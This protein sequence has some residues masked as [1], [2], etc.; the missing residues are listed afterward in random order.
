MTYFVKLTGTGTFPSWSAT[1]D[2]TVSGEV[3]FYQTNDL[4]FGV[5]ASTNGYIG[6]VG[7]FFGVKIGTAFYNT[8]IPVTLSAK[9]AFSI[10]RPIGDSTVSITYGGTT[11]TTSNA[12]TLIIDAIGK[13]DSGGNFASTELDIYLLTLTNGTDN[14]EYDPRVSGGTGTTLTDTVQAKNATLTGTVVWEELPDSSPISFSTLIPFANFHYQKDGNGQGNIVR[15]V[16]FSGAPTSLRYRI[17]DATDDTTVIVDW[18]VFDASPSGGVSVLDILVDASVTPMHMQV[19]NED[20][21]VVSA[22]D[23][24]DFYVG[25]VILIMGQSLAEDMSTDGAV[26]A[27]AGYFKW[28][29]T[30]GVTTA[31]GTG[32]Y[33][34]ARGSI[35]GEGCS[36]LI[37]N[38]TESGTAMCSHAGNGTNHW[39]NIASALF[40]SAITR[41]NAATNGIKKL[42]YVYFHQGTSDSSNGITGDQYLGLGNALGMVNFVSN[43]RRSFGSFDG[44]PLQIYSATL[45]RY[46]SGGTATESSHQ[47]IRDQMLRVIGVDNNLHPINSFV[48]EL[49]DGL[50]GSDAGYT[51]IGKEVNALRLNNLD[52]VTAKAPKLIGVEISEL[53]DELTVIFD[54]S[55]NTTDTTYSKVGIRVEVNG[56]NQTITSYTRGTGAKAV[57]LLASPISTGVS[58]TLWHGYGRGEGSTSAG[59]TYPRAVPVTLPGALGDVSLPCELFVANLF[60][61]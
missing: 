14:R 51:E 59:I 6:N 8:G 12:Q 13:N 5:A 38:S 42:A 23:S 44:N 29:G 47:T 15:N 46:I 40:T 11:V 31:V 48:K 41:V 20:G 9:T 37:I 52:V 36:C 10:S 55:L 1:D 16:I 33:E 2:F 61:V 28:S 58:V 27:L 35:E 24:L 30:A 43:T 49:E 7:G 19:G 45:G 57:I 25:N 50:H 26:P 21:T 3:T 54:T 56:V 18:T 34:L 17:L 22:I 32:A 39:G 53:R 4:I 60:E